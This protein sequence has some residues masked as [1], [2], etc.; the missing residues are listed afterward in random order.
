MF[1][2]ESLATQAEECNTDLDAAHF[3]EVLAQFG[4]RRGLT[5]T[6]L[7]REDSQ[8]PS[9]YSLT[10]TENGP[11]YATLEEFRKDF[12]VCAAGS[13]DQPYALNEHWLV[14]ESSCGS[15]YDDGSGR[16]H[17]CETI[18]DIITETLELH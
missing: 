3:T 17:G 12:T 5:Y 14:F 4:D 7:Y 18:R 2:A 16:P 6:F 10:V 8:E 1:T 11:G 13:T 9:N 15:G